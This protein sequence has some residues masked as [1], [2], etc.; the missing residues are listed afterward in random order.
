MTTEDE[1]VIE[2]VKYILSSR[3]SGII[4]TMKVT[5][6]AYLHCIAINKRHAE[7][8]AEEESLRAKLAGLESQIKEEEP[9]H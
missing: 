3:D 6:D 7:L 4:H 9:I 2:K 1:Q 5:L 8:K